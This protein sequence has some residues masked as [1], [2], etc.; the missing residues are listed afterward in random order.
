MYAHMHMIVYM[1]AAAL[2]ALRRCTS[3]QVHGLALHHRLFIT[4]TS[5]KTRL[6]HEPGDGGAA[7]NYD[8]QYRIYTARFDDAPGP[9]LL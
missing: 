6:L 4:G 9:Y 1:C 2:L 7:G 5:T 3:C 8:K